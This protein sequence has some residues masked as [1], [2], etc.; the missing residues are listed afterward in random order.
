MGVSRPSG[1]PRRRSIDGTRLELAAFTRHQTAERSP[2]VAEACLRV[3]EGLAHVGH[4]AT[5][6]QGTVG[7]STAHGDPASELPAL[8]VALDGD[9]RRRSRTRFEDALTRLGVIR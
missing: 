6:N 3:P 1:G 9:S 4:R 2:Q 8:L 5:P 7:I